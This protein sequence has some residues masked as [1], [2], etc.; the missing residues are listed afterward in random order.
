MKNEL[1]VDFQYLK[2]PY[3]E[4]A[5]AMLGSEW[6]RE[7]GDREHFHNLMEIGICRR[8]TGKIIIDKKRYLYNRDD[9]IVIPRNFSH[10]IVSDPGEKSFWEFIYVK[11]AAF[12]EKV[13]KN[14]V[15]NR[16]RFIE[17]IENRPFVKKKGEAPNISTEINLI[18]DQF[19]VKE[20]EYQNCIKG[21]VFAL[22]ME[23]I[24][25]NHKD[26]DKPEFNKKVTLKKEDT[27]GKALEYI[28]ENY[29]K[30]LHISDIAQAAF[31]SETYL[32]RLFAEC[33]S[34]SPMQY[35]KEIRIDA[36]CKL[37]KNKNM[38]INEVAYKVGYTNITTFI[39]NFKQITGKTPKQW[40]QNKTQKK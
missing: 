7:Y 37:L 13:Y 39:N 5:L 16:E 24:K 25:I 4:N 1:N 35:V 33:C 31:V 21:L 38:N 9:V 23:I 32:R 30:N 2:I 10:T 3:G 18:M 28:E 15:R 20:Y 34:T 12:L 17:E 36:A 8:G 19:R 29:A 6:I 26:Y 40:K 14:Q 22:L 27:L 11:P